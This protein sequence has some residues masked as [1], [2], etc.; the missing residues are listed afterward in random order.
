MKLYKYR[1]YF[2]FFLYFLYKCLKEKNFIFT[3]CFL[4][5]GLRKPDFFLFFFSKLNFFLN[6]ICIRHQKLA[7]HSSYMVYQMM[8]I[9]LCTHSKPAQAVHI[10][11]FSS[12]KLLCIYRILYGDYISIEIDYAFSRICLEF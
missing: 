12:S 4:I 11:I 9:P 6:T 2:H 8:S 3:K 1:L 7:S 10:F 5:C